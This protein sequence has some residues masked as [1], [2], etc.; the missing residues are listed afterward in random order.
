[1]PVNHESKMP[2]GTRVQL[3]LSLNEHSVLAL[4]GEQRVEVHFKLASNFFLVQGTERRPSGLKGF[5]FDVLHYYV[6]LPRLSI[7]IQGTNSWCHKISPLVNEGH[8]LSP[9]KSSYGTIFDHI[10]RRQKRGAVT[11][12]TFSCP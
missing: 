5:P 10:I 6:I 8:V 2:C 3:D 11:S 4:E 12:V 1:M 9:T 7:C